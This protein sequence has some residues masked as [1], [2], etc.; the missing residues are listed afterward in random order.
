MSVDV[1]D[2]GVVSGD[3]GAQ[4]TPEALGEALTQPRGGSGRS[5]AM[6]SMLGGNIA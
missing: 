5:A 1:K 4:F 6:P 3:V 2:V